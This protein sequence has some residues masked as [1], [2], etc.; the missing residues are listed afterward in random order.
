MQHLFSALHTTQFALMCYLYNMHYV[1][2]IVN[3][4]VDTVKEIELDKISN[5]VK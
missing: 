4:D 3:I 1:L 2:A 5:V